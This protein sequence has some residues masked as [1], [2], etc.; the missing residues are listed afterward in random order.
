M[1]T[2]EVYVPTGLETLLKIEGDD[3]VHQASNIT[4]DGITFEY[5]AW[6]RPFTLGTALVQANF[7]V[8]ANGQGSH[9]DGTNGRDITNGGQQA[10]SA[11]DVSLSKY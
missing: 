3:L 5:S 4:F 7:Y 2:A 6:L 8:T 11:I 1:A 10:E 9:T